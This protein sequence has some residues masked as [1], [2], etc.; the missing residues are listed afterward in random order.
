[1]STQ[2][3]YT[4]LTALAG[5]AMVVLLTGCAVGP[6]YKRPD[7]PLPAAYPDEAG[8]GAVG[9]E[10]GKLAADWWTLY[11][12]ATLNDLV[13]GALQN[14]TDLHR[15]VAQIDEAQAV[16]DEASSTLFPE[17]DLGASS[18]RSRISSLNAQPLF[19]GQP[20]I[21]TTNRLALSC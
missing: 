9:T 19:S 12:D 2:R 20:Q 18:S 4:S 21:S 16:L 5:L 3:S 11:N 15:A 6:D 14:N 13:A 8:A 1:M 10:Q 17:I 7:V